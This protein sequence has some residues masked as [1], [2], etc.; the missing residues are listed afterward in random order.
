MA[1]VFGTTSLSGRATAHLSMSQVKALE[2]VERTMSVIS[3]LG[4]VLLITTFLICPDLKRKAFNRLLF[5][6]S[7]GNI[8]SNVATLVA[9]SGVKAGDHSA[10]CKAQA[11]LIQW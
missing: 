5:L 11:T 2:A 3:I 9:T 8:L 10:L 7:F 1:E 6:A 4:C